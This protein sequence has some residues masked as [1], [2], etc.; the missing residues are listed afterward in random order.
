LGEDP[1]RPRVDGF[2]MNARIWEQLK[3]LDCGIGQG[4]HL[5]RPIPALE[6][7]EWLAHYNAARS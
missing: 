3:E 1:G 6:L 5:S 4:Y 2:G 7:V